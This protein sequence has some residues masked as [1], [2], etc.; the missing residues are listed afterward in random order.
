MAWLD[1]YH[2]HLKVT[3]NQKAVQ[4]YQDK[5]FSFELFIHWS[6]FKQLKLPEVILI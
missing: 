3:C 2:F 6:L 5:D 1:C 4:A